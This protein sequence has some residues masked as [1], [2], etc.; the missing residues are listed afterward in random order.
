MPAP[1]APWLAA[2]LP[3]QRLPSGSASSA[4]SIKLLVGFP[5][6]L[7]AVIFP[8]LLHG[9]VFYLASR[10]WGCHTVRLTAP[11]H[12]WECIPHLCSCCDLLWVLAKQVQISFLYG[13]P[14][15]HKW[16][17]SE[18]IVP[19]VRDGVLNYLNN[20][21]VKCPRWEVQVPIPWPHP[22]LPPG[23]STGRHR[24]WQSCCKTW[25]STAC[26]ASAQQPNAH[27]SY[28]ALFPTLHH[29]GI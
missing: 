19:T 20:T 25:D 12:I 13:G 28:P 18:P 9:V 4:I 24:K 11:L 3:P 29:V 7:W 21:I 5:P 16:E 26:P 14:W 27:S 15:G 23:V 10:K 17:L 1:P 8:L 22:V 2:Q 6:P